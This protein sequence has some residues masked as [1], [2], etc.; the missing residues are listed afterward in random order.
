MIKKCK[1]SK[2]KEIYGVYSKGNGMKRE[3]CFV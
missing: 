1:N 3:K 2:H